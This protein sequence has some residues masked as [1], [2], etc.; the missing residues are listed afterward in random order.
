MLKDKRTERVAG[1]GGIKLLVYAYM[2]R[3][4]RG[5]SQEEAQQRNKKENDPEAL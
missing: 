2:K 4:R 1:K 3:A 5:F